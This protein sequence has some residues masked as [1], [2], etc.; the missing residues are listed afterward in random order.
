MEGKGM[1][2]E[3]VRTRSFRYED[4]SIRRVFLQSYPLQW[5]EDDEK[6][7][8]TSQVSEESTGKRPIKKTI[9][10]VFHWGGE[11]VFVLRRFKQKVTVYAIACIP[12]RIKE[13]SALISA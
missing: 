12:I 4:Y 1:D 9:L 8:E 3:G 5:R 7:E 6:S 10:S 11:K 2:E 13:P